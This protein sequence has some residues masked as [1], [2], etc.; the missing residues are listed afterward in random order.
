MIRRMKFFIRDVL[1]LT[2]VVGL[3]LG[4]WCWWRSLPLPVEGFIRGTVLISG[5]PISTGRVFLHSSDGQFRGTQVSKGSFE[6]QGIPYGKYSLTFEGDNAPPNKFP[7]EL[8]DKC[9]ALGATFNIG[10][11]APPSLI[12]SRPS[13]PTQ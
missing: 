3:A 4:W 11:P 6:L 2:L 13:R 12:S 7:A 8:N 1:W 5:K 10:P 9:Q